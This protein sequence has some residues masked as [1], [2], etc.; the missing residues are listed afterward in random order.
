MKCIIVS[1]KHQS[2]IVNTYVIKM[3]KYTYRASPYRGKPSIVNPVLK[4]RPLKVD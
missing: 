4:H 1:S 2:G 3:I